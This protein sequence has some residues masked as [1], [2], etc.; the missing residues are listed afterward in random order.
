MLGELRTTCRSSA[1]VDDAELA[2][3]NIS[4]PGAS[5]KPRT[6]VEAS[7]K[8]GAGG[9]APYRKIM[10]ADRRRTLDVYDDL[11]DAAALARFEGWRPHEVDPIVS[12]ARSLEVTIWPALV[13]RLIADAAETTTVM[14]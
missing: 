5:T 4:P 9:I 12:A 3:L 2:E 10:A 13:R 8:A 14:G 6:E 1:S 7:A 11:L